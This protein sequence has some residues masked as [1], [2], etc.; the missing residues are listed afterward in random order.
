MSQAEIEIVSSEED[1][2]GNITDTPA[3]ED[4]GPNSTVDAVLSALDDAEESPASDEPG[5]KDPDD[6]QVESTDG[7]AGK[8]SK[9]EDSSEE[10]DFSE[11]EKAQLNDK[12][13]ARIDTLLEQRK[14]NLER[15][16]K[17]EQELETVRADAESYQ[18]ISGYLNDNNLTA[19]DAGDALN[20]AR[21]VVNDPI[22]AHAQLSALMEKLAPLVGETLP[23][24]LAEDVRL[25]RITEERAKELARAKA[26]EAQSGRQAQA[27]QDREKARKEEEDQQREQ[28][29]RAKHVSNLITIGDQL[30]ADRAQSD[31]DWKLKEKRVTKE[32]ELKFY[33]DGIPK[34]EEEFR[35]IFDET[36]IS[37]TAELKELSPQKTD[38]TNPVTSS[39]STA[40]REQAKETPKDGVDA[41]LQALN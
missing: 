13:R 30:A 15:A 24:D 7:E 17:A 16:E 31:P 35:K 4:Q 8:D 20:M 10:D 18:K 41:V 11:E 22:A 33:K 12:T 1:Q 2:G 34:T 5:S 26:S 19:K 6:A 3:V 39:S 38:A 27:E 36:V 40:V 32:L 28:D 29:K 37:V 9:P 14:E 21:L 23:P 25:G